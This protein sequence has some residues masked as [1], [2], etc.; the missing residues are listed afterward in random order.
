MTHF[1]AEPKLTL[2]P[3]DQ[4]SG[5][6]SHQNSPSIYIYIYTPP[7]LPPQVF[8]KKNLKTPK[9]K[10]KQW[11]DIKYQNTI[12]TVQ[13]SGINGSEITPK[14]LSATKIAIPFKNLHNTKQEPRKISETLKLVHATHNP[15]T[16]KRTQKPNSSNKRGK[17]KPRLS[18]GVFKKQ[19]KEIYNRENKNKKQ[20][21]IPRQFKSKIFWFS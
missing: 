18:Q 5:C 10:E 16:K 14:P 2:Q 7:P 6:L 3:L 21:H 19:I 9:R 20:K 11:S 17:K 8:N 13:F 12:W 1:D 15:D 4:C